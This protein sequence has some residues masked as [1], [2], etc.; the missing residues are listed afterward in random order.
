MKNPDEYYIN[1]NY[2]NT[3]ED[4]PYVNDIFHQKNY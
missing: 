2:I 1:K 4:N 3:L